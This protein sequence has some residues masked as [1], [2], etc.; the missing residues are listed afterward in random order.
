MRFITM[1]EWEWGMGGG[2]LKLIRSSV[3]MSYPTLYEMKLATLVPYFFSLLSEPPSLC[4]CLFCNFTIASIASAK[5]S[6][7]M[8]SA[9]IGYRATYVV[10]SKELFLQLPLDD[11]RESRYWF[12]S[13]DSRDSRRTT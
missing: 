1:R 6:L 7:K 8:L 3:C 10:I 2:Q 11:F 9:S 4:S 12:F 5:E 13:E